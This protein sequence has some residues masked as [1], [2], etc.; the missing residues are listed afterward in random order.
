LVSRSLTVVIPTYNE[1]ANLEPI[2]SELFTT[3][4]FAHV[5][6]VD[7]GS[8]DGT[9][10]LA[11]EIA[12]RDSRLTVIHRPRKEGIGPAY[13]AGFSR[14]LDCET[15]LIAA[16]DADGSHSPADLARM[17]EAA[18]DADLVVGSRYVDGGQT[19]GWPRW[20]RSLSRF[21]GLYARLV[22][23]APISDL[24]SGFKVYRRPAL[25]SL[26]LD[27]IRTDGYGFQI[28]TT[29]HIWRSGL[30]VREA[31][32]TFHDRI[33]GKSKLSRRIVIEAMVMVWR[34]RFSDR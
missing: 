4:P 7:D 28:E 19:V 31:P 13:I 30:R 32:I 17:I 8:P 3:L 20:R 15:E 14:A 29:W 5:V 10:K 23:G 2:L 1:C 16:M 26:P 21:G 11:D 18:G 9:G 6:V 25:S 24:T 27:R 34:L 12:R 33:A 22:L